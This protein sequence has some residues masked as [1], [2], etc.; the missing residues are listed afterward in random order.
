MTNWLHD[1]SWVVPYRTELATKFFEAL[2]WLGYPTFIMLLLAL[3]YWLWSQ[4]TATRMMVLVILS[5]VLNAFL[6]DYFKDPR[7]DPVFHLDPGVG[8]SFGLPSGHT[9]IAVVLWYGL[10]L[11]IRQKWMWILATLLIVGIAFSRIYLGIHDLEDVLSGGLI[12]FASLWLYVQLTRPRTLYL[13]NKPVWIYLAAVVVLQML[14]YRLWP[15]PANT[16]AALAL[17]GTLFGWL[18]GNHINYLRIGFTIKPEWWAFLLVVVLGVAGLSGFT[19][20]LRPW[21]DTFSPTVASYSM[22][23]AIALYMTIIAPAL[24]K[25]IGL[26]IRR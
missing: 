5:T 19:S 22:T 26:S 13:R 18:L 3:S 17:V 24:F 25:L 12:G 6:K 14:L 8:N 1:V 10:A 23:F 16:L 2:T 7:P 4:K 20:L 11:E 15:A 21:F 9:Q